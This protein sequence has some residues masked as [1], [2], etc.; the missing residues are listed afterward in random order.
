MKKVYR[1]LLGLYPRDYRTLF[2][3]GMLTAFHAT[4]EERRAAGRA[5]LALFVATELAGLAMGAA[6][7]WMAKLTTDPS[8]RG[9]SLPDLVKMR[10]PGVSWEAHYK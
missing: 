6:S 4:A 9:R 10:P 3:A 8:I 5:A 7:E 1:A 2:A